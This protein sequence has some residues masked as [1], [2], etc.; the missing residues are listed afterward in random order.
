MYKGTLY[1]ENEHGQIWKSENKRWTITT[2]YHTPGKAEWIIENPHISYYD[3]P[4]VLPN[5][6]IT[7][8]KAAKLPTYVRNQFLEMVKDHVTQNP[9]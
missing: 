6:E 8:N 3:N 1:K 4:K 9:Q 5:G 7:F 2:Y